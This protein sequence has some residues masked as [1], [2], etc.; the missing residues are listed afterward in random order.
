MNKCSWIKGSGVLGFYYI[1]IFI[2]DV[3]VLGFRA[4]VGGSTFRVGD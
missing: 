1:Y 2:L 3:G 4:S